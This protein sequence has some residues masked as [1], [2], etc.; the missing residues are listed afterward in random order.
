V[1]AAIL[2]GEFYIASTVLIASKKTF[3]STLAVIIGGLGNIILNLIFIPIYGVYGAALAK[4]FSFFAMFLVVYLF[5]DRD[6]RIKLSEMAGDLVS[7]LTGSVIVYFVIYYFNTSLIPRMMIFLGLAFLV[8]GIFRID[9]KNIA[10]IKN[11]LFSGSS[12]E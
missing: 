8:T 4:P 5:L 7:F 1:L 9:L 3:Q 10:K 6:I 12:S 2:K 11:L